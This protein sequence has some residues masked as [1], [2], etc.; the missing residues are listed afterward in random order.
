MDVEPIDLFHCGYAQTVAAYVTDTRDGPA[1]IDCGPTA[2]VGALESGLKA[3]GL[4]PADIRHLFLT[5]IHLDHAGAAGYLVRENPELRVY[6]G[7]AGLVHLAYPVALENGARRIYG[8]RFDVLWGEVTGVPEANLRPAE[9][10]IC[11]LECVPTPG[12]CAH[13]VAY[14]DEGGTLFAGDAAGVRIPPATYVSPPT[15]PPEFDLAAWYRSIDELERT[16]PRR[17]ALT[18]FGVVADPADHLVRLRQRLVA[19]SA[20]VR[21]GA[22]EAEFADVVGAE[23]A[24]HPEQSD[25]HKVLDI[26][27]LYRGITMS[28][29]RT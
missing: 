19:W 15:S 5:H 10:T 29:D 25:Y 17:L 3:R 8:S 27:W 13:H 14:L 9:G 26:V 28:L 23:L 12:H 21:G 24:A 20:L 18:H 16:A 7:E 22:G 11:G 2:T 4:R 6:V 1:L